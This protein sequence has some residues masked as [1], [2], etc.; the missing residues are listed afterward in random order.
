MNQRDHQPDYQASA[1]CAQ[2]SRRF[3]RLTRCEHGETAMPSDVRKV[4]DLPLPVK[5][6]GLRPISA[7]QPQDW[8]VSC[9]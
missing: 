7:A 4:S 9:R 2:V 6:S 5:T 3:G 8:S 1:G